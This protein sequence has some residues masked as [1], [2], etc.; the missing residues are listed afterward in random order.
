MFYKG[1]FD[2]S[3]FSLQIEPKNNLDLLRSGKLHLFI[4]IPET[5]L[6]NAKHIT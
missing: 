2:I 1:Y 4:T 6:T 3:N 5:D